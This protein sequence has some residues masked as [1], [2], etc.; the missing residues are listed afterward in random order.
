MDGNGFWDAL[1]GVAVGAFKGAM[2]TLVPLLTADDIQ[3]QL[4]WLV[5]NGVSSVVPFAQSNW[6]GTPLQLT[7]GTAGNY[8]IFHIQS[9]PNPTLQRSSL[10]LNGN[11]YQPIARSHGKKITL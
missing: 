6:T 7:C 10:L 5:S 4:S 9:V 1:R 8:S 2:Q 11:N 3:A